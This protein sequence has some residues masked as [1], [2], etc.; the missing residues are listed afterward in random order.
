VEDDDDEE[1]ADEAAM[2]EFDERCRN[3]F[4]NVDLSGLNT[5]GGESGGMDAV[6][7]YPVGLFPQEEVKDRD[8]AAAPESSS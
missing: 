4:K 1:V 8:D 2:A 5:A 7:V 3:I 6:G